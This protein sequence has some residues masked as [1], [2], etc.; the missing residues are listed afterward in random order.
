MS[1]FYMM[2]R[3]AIAS[4]L[5]ILFA[6]SAAAKVQV[7]SRDLGAIDP[8]RSETMP[9][10]E[11][12][13]LIEKNPKHEVYFVTGTVDLGRGVK[14]HNKYIYDKPK[15]ILLLMSRTVMPVG[16]DELRWRVWRDIAPVDFKEGLPFNNKQLTT[17]TSPFR[18]AK[19]TVP[20]KYPDQPKITEWP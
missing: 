9:A 3:M 17:E 7:A 4:A 20:F 13:R 19:E 1:A 18:A 8:K 10:V 5:V 12:Y 15:R 11:L 2:I 6:T 14:D 16:S